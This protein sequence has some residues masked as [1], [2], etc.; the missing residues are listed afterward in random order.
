[1]CQVSWGQLGLID[2]CVELC[3]DGVEG[4]LERGVDGAHC[5]ENGGEAGAQ[6]AVIEACEEQGCTQSEFGDAVAQ[7]VGQTFDQAVETQA[8]KLIGECALRDRLW[9]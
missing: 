5:G 3:V 4:A 8:A 7:A 6:K 2:P 1:M 9:I